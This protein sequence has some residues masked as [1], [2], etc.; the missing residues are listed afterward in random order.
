MVFNLPF[1]HSQNDAEYKKPKHLR[2][3]E[4]FGFIKGQNNSLDIIKNKYPEL[5][6]SAFRAQ[7]L[8]KAT[9]GNCLEKMQNFLISAFE[10]E[11][12]TAFEN[13]LNEEVKKLTSK[14]DLSEDVAIS[15]I[16]EVEERAK[17][18]IPSPILETLLSFKYADYPQFEFIDGFV[19]VF[20]TK[21]HPKSKG[22]DWQ[23][24]VPKS[25]RKAEAE[26][27]NIIQKFISD[28]GDGNQSIMLLVKNLDLPEGYILSKEEIDEMFSEEEMKKIAVD[29]TKFIS[30]TKTTI[31]NKIAVILEVEKTAE[32]LDIKTKI[33][34]QQYMFIHN[35]KMYCMEGMVST[36]DLS[37]DLAAEMKKYNPVFRLVANSIVL[38]DKYR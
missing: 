7:N 13:K 27:P 16:L 8:F 31:E 37:K 28:Y 36:K 12:F 5:E 34:M 30:Y 32:R 11:G 20:N 23:I 25:W 19:N 24:K 6:M 22:T 33:R 4:A 2:V 18:N 10:E 15:F 3:S 9:Y 21:G 26:R 29:G 17:G 1:I 35:N 38:K 14:I